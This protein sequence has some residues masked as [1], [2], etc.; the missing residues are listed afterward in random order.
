MDNPL[1]SQ[2]HESVLNCRTKTSSKRRSR[3]DVLDMLVE[4]W[5]QKLD[6]K[7]D[8]LY[9]KRVWGI[10]P[11]KVEVYSRH[12]VVKEVG[13]CHR[14]TVRTAMSCLFGRLGE[15]RT[16][17]LLVRVIMKYVTE[18]QK[19]KK[20]NVC[21]IYWQGRCCKKIVKKKAFLLTTA[22]MRC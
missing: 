13:G 2:G 5:N 1:E 19:S 14:M 10:I 12:K 21:L 4:Q 15:F 8:S 22:R 11:H 3:Y 6:G 17:R 9:T 7:L 20:K 18:C 16:M